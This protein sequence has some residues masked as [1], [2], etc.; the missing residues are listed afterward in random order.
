MVRPSVGLRPSP[1]MLDE[2]KIPV[3]GSSTTSVEIV[4]D[5]VAECAELVMRDPLLA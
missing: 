5:D 2:T 1:L 3:I 4:K